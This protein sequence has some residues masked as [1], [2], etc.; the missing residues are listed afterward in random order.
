MIYEHCATVKIKEYPDAKHRGLPRA[1]QDERGARLRGGHGYPPSQFTAV[2]VGKG[3]VGRR[4]ALFWVVYLHPTSAEL[5]VDG[6]VPTENGPR[7]SDQ[8]A[9]DT[10]SDPNRW[11]LA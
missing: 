8:A 7:A 9:A 3:E 10:K 4:V 11:I 2:T 1:C 6:R 5:C